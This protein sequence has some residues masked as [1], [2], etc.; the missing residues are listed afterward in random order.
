ML[1]VGLQR[2]QGCSSLG[3]LALECAWNPHTTV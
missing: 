2:R 3:N 1:L